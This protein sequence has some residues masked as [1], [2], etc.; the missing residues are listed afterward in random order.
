VNTK[1]LLQ[2]PGCQQCLPWNPILRNPAVVAD[3]KA[4][5]VLSSLAL[6]WLQQLSLGPDLDTSSA[7][8]PSP[9]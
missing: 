8:Q 2:S 9:L 7:K 3:R 1:Q 4:K 5:T 6:A